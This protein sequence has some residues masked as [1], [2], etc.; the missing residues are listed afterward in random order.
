MRFSIVGDDEK[1]S[2]TTSLGG[3]DA[4]ELAPAPA[5][6]SSLTQRPTR[7][8]AADPPTLTQPSISQKQEAA[9]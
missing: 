8:E 9:T 7:K 3:E 2:V 6:A 5:G 4:A 1:V